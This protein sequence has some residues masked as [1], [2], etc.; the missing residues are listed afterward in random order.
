MTRFMIALTAATLSAA[1]VAPTLAQTSLLDGKAFVADG[2][3]KGKAADEL[4]DVLTFKDGKFHSSACDKYGYGV[5]E[6]KATKVG[7][8]IE[9]TAE[10]MSEK[11]GKNV[12]KGTI[13][14]ADIEGTFVH[15]Q[16]GWFLN[17]NPDPIDHWFKGKAK[18]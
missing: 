16:K 7:D 10:T 11:H 2:G 18:T 1:F 15:H 14:G 3:I 9:W 12:W 8:T 6:Y 5:G 13:K 4:G 17:P